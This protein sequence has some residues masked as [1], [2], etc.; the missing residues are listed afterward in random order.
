MIIGKPKA[1]GE[2]DDTTRIKGTCMKI[3]DGGMI[4]EPCTKKSSLEKR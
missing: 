4:D 2:D 3:R 1:Q